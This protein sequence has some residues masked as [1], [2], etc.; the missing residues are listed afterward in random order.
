M[1]IHEIIGLMGL[2]S[3]APEI[4]QFFETNGLGKPPKSVNANQGQ[5]S[6]QDK[7]NQLSF[8]FK[9]DITHEKFHP[10]VSPKRDDYNFDCYLYSVVLF[11]GSGR[12]NIA[13]PK[14][15]TFWEAF[16]NPQSSYSECLTLFNVNEKKPGTVLR[17]PLNDVAEVVVWFSK[18]QSR[19]TT[20][21]LRIIEARELFSMYDF[22][23]RYTMNTVKQAYALL[24]KWLLDNRYLLL[25][26]HVYQ[27]IPGFDEKTILDFTG[28]YLKNHLW[29]TQL[30]D[31]SALITFLYAIAS[32]SN[33]TT[34][35]GE[36]VNVYIKH[37]YIK[38]AGKWDQHQNMYIKETM[39][40]VDEFERNLYLDET[41]SKKFLQTLTD[42][43][44]LFK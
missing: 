4:G 25:P 43:F 22:D 16:I 34:S 15:A 38:A 27:A 29:T 19:I 2:K 35:G 9:Y 32:N 5:K 14:P 18:D 44:E 13:D 8:G 3:T 17:K 10:P 11:E 30:I 41:Q 6:V 28:K 42:Q 20:I 40:A 31:D 7:K 26:A 36:K 33:S 23:T 24:V 39:E 1:T 12:K 21:E 37:L